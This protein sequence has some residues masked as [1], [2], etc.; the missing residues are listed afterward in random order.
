MSQVDAATK[1]Q[2]EALGKL[3]LPEVRAAIRTVQDA[4]VDPPAQV[5]AHATKLFAREAL[6]QMRVEDYACAV[7]PWGDQ[8]AAEWQADCP[9]F[10]HC[11]VQPAEEAP[12]EL[13]GFFATW[14]EAV[15]NDEWFSVFHRALR[16]PAPML[17]IIGRVLTLAQARAGTE[18]AWMK[19]RAAPAFTALRGVAA[20]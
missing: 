2:P 7:I 8:G 19:G 11:G 15:F 4:G 3:T 10:G 6:L 1:L 18:L 5:L 12:G 9:C 16:V 14:V 20:V 13:G 17:S